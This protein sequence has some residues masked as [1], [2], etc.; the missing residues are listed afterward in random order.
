[1]EEQTIRGFYRETIKT[2]PIGNLTQLKIMD[3][4][5]T[6]LTD[7]A[8]I[9]ISQKIEFLE[10]LKLI[11]VQRITDESIKNLILNS[12]ICKSLKSLSLTSTS[13]GDVGLRLIGSFF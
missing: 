13:I 12:S 2:A 8:I 10:V 3:L 11:E 6:K 5:Y 9:E 4:S 1:M 7:E